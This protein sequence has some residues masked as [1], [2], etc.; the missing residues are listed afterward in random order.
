MFVK[1]HKYNYT[2][3]DPLNFN[4]P[5]GQFESLTEALTSITINS[6]LTSYVS[7]AVTPV[8][9]SFASYLIPNSIIDTILGAVEYDAFLIG[10]NFDVSQ[11]LKA[12]VGIAGGFGVDWLW[13]HHTNRAAAYWYP[14]IGV[15]F[16]QTNTSLGGLIHVG[17]VWRA[18]DS[19][20]YR[21]H[22]FTFT[23]PFDALPVAVKEKVERQL[24]VGATYLVGSFLPG[25]GVALV[26]R[27]RTAIV[28]ARKEIPS[29][30]GD[31]HGLTAHIF[32]DPYFHTVGISPFRAAEV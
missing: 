30:L 3:G 24:E 5:T 23:L 25:N 32:S 12:R 29:F 14:S 7:A 28:E 4:D 16:G 27:L 15:S 17:F 2:H 11:T 13:S 19:K 31:V 10:G 8:L 21:R 9:H 6:I 20:S 18:Q 22:F 1:G 26:S